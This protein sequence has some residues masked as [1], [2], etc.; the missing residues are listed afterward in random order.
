M[1]CNQL[2]RLV[3]EWYT[4]V[5]QETMAP[6]RMM[7]FVDSHVR[8][9][10]VCREDRGLAADIDLVR[11]RILPDSKLSRSSRFLSSDTLTPD[12]FQ[13]EDEEDSSDPPEDAEA[14]GLF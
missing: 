10:E 1:Q 14:D 9:C 12:I 11:E 8:E 6:A 7:Q 13:S 3:K 4:H 5:R 2:I